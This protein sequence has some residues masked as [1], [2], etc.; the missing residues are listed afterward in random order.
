VKFSPT[1]L[2]L[3]Q[4]LESTDWRSRLAIPVTPPHLGRAVSR[5]AHSYLEILNSLPGEEARSVPVL[6]GPSIIYHS[7]TLIEAAFIVQAELNGFPRI[8]GGIPELDYLRTGDKTALAGDGWS[9]FVPYRAEETPLAGLRQLKAPLNWGPLW[10]LPKSILSSNAVISFNSHLISDVKRERRSAASK[11]A[12]HLLALARKENFPSQD[13][14]PEALVKMVVSALTNIAEIAPELRNRL[15]ALISPIVSASFTQAANDLN[16]LHQFSNLPKGVVSGTGSKY[17]ARAVGIEVKRRGGLVERYEHGGPCG[18]VSNLEVMMLCDIIVSTSYVMMSKPKIDLFLGLGPTR[19]FPN[20]MNVKIR[21]GA[22][23]PQFVP[24][25]SSRHKSSRSKQMKILYGPTKFRGHEQHDPPLLMDTVY[26]D[27][28]IRLV[29]N[30]KEL[31]ANVTL[32]PHPQSPSGAWRKEFS[33]SCEFSSQTFETLI[34]QA[35]L[36]ICDYPQSTTFWA[37]LCSD[38]PVVLI[39]LGISVL[40]PALMDVY[41]RRCA[42]VKASYDANGIPH[43]DLETLRGAI[44]GQPNRADPT[45]IRQYFFDDDLNKHYIHLGTAPVA[46]K[47]PQAAGPKIG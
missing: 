36:I 32:R 15:E 9:T 29:E 45:E 27:W 43:V 47:T 23:D 39:D 1:S 42:I 19:S 44:H 7:H 14:A 5:S 10:R 16:A 4:A 18:M 41:A 24:V 21:S 31:P 38:R 28:Q 2:D 6:A 8:A 33:S 11:N 34:P 13:E 12:S 17:A 30:L 37:S 35:D 3:N 26:L 40:N 46:T 25:S 20:L 22:G